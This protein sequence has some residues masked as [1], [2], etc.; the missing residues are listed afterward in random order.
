[1]LDSL[2]QYKRPHPT[3]LIM[4]VL[5]AI[6]SMFILFVLAFISYQTRHEPP[7][8]LVGEREDTLGKRSGAI[9]RKKATDLDHLDPYEKELALKEYN[10]KRKQ[11]MMMATAA[12]AKTKSDF[13]GKSE[14]F[15]SSQASGDVD[16]QSRNSV[17]RS[18]G[19]SKQSSAFA[20]QAP[21]LTEGF[22]SSQTLSKTL[23]SN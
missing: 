19:Q 2:F 15:N 10:M 13:S 1:M 23:M 8:A 21:I 16:Q 9:L 20:K 6:S 5:I 11:E 12:A 17:E 3:A 4:G 22:S 18:A 7:N 14:K